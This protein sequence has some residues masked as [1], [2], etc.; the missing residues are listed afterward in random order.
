MPNPRSRRS[1]FSLLP[2]PLAIA[3]ALGACSSPPEKPQDQVAAIQAARQ[4]G[5]VPIAGPV[6]GWDA[7]WT[8]GQQ[9][10]EVSWLAPAVAYASTS[11]LGKPLMCRQ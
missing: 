9:P 4:G 7:T 10:L 5:Y 1:R 11:T 3:L 6:Q 2:L 8:L